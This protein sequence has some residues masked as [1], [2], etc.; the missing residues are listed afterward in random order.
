[1]S[2]KYTQTG[3]KIE[4]FRLSV[5]LRFYLHCL[6]RVPTPRQGVMMTLKNGLEIHYLLMQVMFS[7]VCVCSGKWGAGYPGLWSHVPSQPLVPDP[8][9][10]GHTS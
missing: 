2:I 1:M 7:Q 5:P 8:F 10:G 9:G 6:S 4:Y 3:H